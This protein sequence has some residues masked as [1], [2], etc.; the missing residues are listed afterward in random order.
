MSKNIPWSSGDKIS[1]QKQSVLTMQSEG[2][3]AWSLISLLGDL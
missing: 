1:L 2:K 3:T